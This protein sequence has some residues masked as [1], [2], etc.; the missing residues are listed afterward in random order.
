MWGSNSSLLIKKLW[1]FSSLPIW[2]PLGVG[3]MVSLF[4]PLLPACLMCGRH[5]ASD[6]EF[7]II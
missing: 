2:D 4:Q 1:A 7:S 3:V 5:S 6:E